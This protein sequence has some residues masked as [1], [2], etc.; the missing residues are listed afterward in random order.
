M[1]KNIILCFVACLIISGIPIIINDNIGN[2]NDLNYITE[3]FTV[4]DSTGKEYIVDLTIRKESKLQEHKHNIIVILSN[5][6]IQSISFNEKKLFYE[7]V[8]KNNKDILKC[9]VYKLEL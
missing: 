4:L 1:I 6:N 3:N 9:E 7:Y 8:G 2:S 5:I